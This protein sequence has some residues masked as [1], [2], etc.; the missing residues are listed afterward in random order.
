[1]KK[2]TS[3]VILLIVLINTLI[4]FLIDFYMSISI[5]W[6]YGAVIALIEVPII[7]VILKMFENKKWAFLIGIIYYFLRSFN[8]YLEKFTF[9]T[10]NGINIELSMFD[11][12]GINL[13]SLIILILIIVAYN[14]WN[15]KLK[16][17]KI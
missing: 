12:I 9:Y 16:T 4:A 5:S 15:K 14:R 3:N 1:M 8:F 13:I 10:K 2:Y 11:K 17:T 6:K 7:Y